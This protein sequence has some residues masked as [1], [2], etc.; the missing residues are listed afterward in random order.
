[1]EIAELNIWGY[2]PI[3]III[4]TLVTHPD[5]LIHRLDICIN[6]DSKIEAAAASS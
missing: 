3:T 6:A 2:T 5:E 4:Y 1:M